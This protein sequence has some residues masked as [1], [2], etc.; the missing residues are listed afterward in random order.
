M[1][2]KLNELEEGEIGKIVSFDGTSQLKRHLMGL[3]FIQGAELRLQKIAPLGDPIEIK[4]KGCSI[5]LRKEE[6]ANIKIETI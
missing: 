6:A 1:I 2:K 5:S 4:I 3:G